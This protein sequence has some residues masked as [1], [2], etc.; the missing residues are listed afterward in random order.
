MEA[1]FERPRMQ[2]ELS[3]VAVV[4]QRDSVR[5]QQG[6]PPPNVVFRDFCLKANLC[7]DGTALLKKAE[8]TRQPPISCENIR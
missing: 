3:S 2:A 8:N 4:P 6:F 5:R 1:S 7:A